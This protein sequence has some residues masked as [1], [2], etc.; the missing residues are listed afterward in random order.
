M[1]Y[2]QVDACFLQDLENF[3]AAQ[4]ISQGA[5]WQGADYISYHLAVSVDVISDKHKLHSAKFWD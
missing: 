4:H 2:L 5:L 1:P 3:R